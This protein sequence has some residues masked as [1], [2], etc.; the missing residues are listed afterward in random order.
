LL[1]RKLPWLKLYFIIICLQHS[2]V[3]WNVFIFT[4]LVSNFI[5]LFFIELLRI[6]LRKTII[7]F[8]RT[9]LQKYKFRKFVTLS[10]TISSCKCSFTTVIALLSTSKHRIIISPFKGLFSINNLIDWFSKLFLWGTVIFV[11][12][13]ILSTNLAFG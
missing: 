9:S 13:G 10:I 11:F 12:R 2:L 1:V 6:N 4:V 5:K 8:K 3:W 7:L